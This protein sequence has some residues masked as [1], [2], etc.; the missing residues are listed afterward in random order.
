SRQNN[1]VNRLQARFKLAENANAHAASLTHA[2]NASSERR[3]ENFRIIDRQDGD[4]ACGASGDRLFEGERKCC[5]IVAAER[6]IFA[7]FVGSESGYAFEMAGGEDREG[8]PERALSM[9]ERRQSFAECLHKRFCRRKI[10]LAY[11]APRVIAVKLL[12]ADAI[13]RQRMR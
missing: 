11:E 4:F 3:L 13:G 9:G 8:H 5:A 1:A 7:G 2:H 10:A 6:D 12:A